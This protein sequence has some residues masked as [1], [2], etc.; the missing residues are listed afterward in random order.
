MKR[1]LPLLFFITS[2]ASFA[3]QGAPSCA[4]LAA[5]SSQYQ[6]C[7]TTITFASSTN[8]SSGE[9]Y[10]PSCFDTNL[11][12]PSWF[13]IKI[14]T[15]GSINFQIQQVNAAGN[16]ADVDFTLWGP[17]T[18]LTNVCSSLT[19]AREVDCSYSP[20]GLENVTLPNGVAGELYVLVIDNFSQTAGNITITQTGGDG[21]SDCSFLSDVDILDDTGNEIL[22]LDYCQP[23]TKNLVA[24]VDTSDF[25]GNPADLRFNY[26]WYKDTVLVYTLTDD[27]SPTNTYVAADSGIYRVEMTSYDVTDP[28]LDPS[29]LTV[30]ADEITLNFYEAPIV[31]VTTS[32]NCLQAAPQLQATVSNLGAAPVSYQWFRGTTSILGA[33]TATYTPTQAGTYFVQASNPGCT[34]VNSNSIVIY[35]IPTVNITGT[36]AICED[37][38]YTLTSAVANTGSATITYQWNKG[39]NPIPGANGATFVVS[40]ANQSPGASE[41]YTL[42]L[43]LDGSCSSVS[44]AVTITLNQKPALAS[45]PVVLKQCDYIAPNTDGVAIFDLTQA[46]TALT[47]NTAGITLSYFLDA[48]LTQQIANP[49]LFTNTTPFNQTLYVTGQFP[50]QVPVCTSNVA[51]LQLDVDPTSVAS[52]PNLAPVCPE[53]NQGFGFFDF[54]TQRALIKTTYFPATNVNIAFYANA[55]DAAVENGALDNT[56][57]IPTGNNTIYTRI[58]TNNDCAGIGTFSADV[59]IAPALTNVVDWELCESEPVIF[60]AKDSEALTG[61]AATVST[62]YFASFENARQNIAAFDKNADANFPI[63]TTTVYARLSDSA[64]GCFSIIDFDVKVYDEPNITAPTPMSNCSGSVGTFNLDSRIAQITGGNANYGVQFFASQAD[65]DSGIAITNTNAYQSGNRTVLI[66]VTDPTQHGCTSQTTL[67]LSVSERPGAATN[68]DILQLCDD[69]GFHAFDL[70]ERERQMAGPTPLAE[71]E[72][73]YYE[74][75]DSAEANSPDWIADPTQYVNRDPQYQKIYVRIN[76]KTSFDSETG[77]PCYRVLE[78]ELFVRH[79]PPDNLLKTPYHICVDKDGN[80]VSPALIE[81]GLSEGFQFTWYE[82]PDAVPGSERPTNQSFFVAT[83]PGT[84]SVRIVDFR[85]TS[86]CDI[87]INFTVRNTEVP[88]SISGNPADLIAF[89]TDNT[90]TAVVDPPSSDYEY[91][92]D[93]NGWQDSNVFVDVKEGLYRLTVRSKYGCGEV[94]TDVVVA[95]FPRFFTPNGD[96]FHDTWNI[97]GQEALDVSV[98]YVFDRNGKLLRSIFR[99]DTGWDGTY[100]GRPMPADDYWFVVLYTKGGITKEFRSHF[101]LKR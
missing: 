57:P 67:T 12:G 65:F 13:F 74:S 54:E 70:T 33:T 52:Y 27:T 9:S 53:L 50:G 36:T 69:S 64:T 28:P 71:L 79:S 96:G 25:T 34:A 30:S 87:V 58:E 15:S 73:F 18:S 66:L 49:S 2:L 72:F 84:Y 76:S 40:S 5:N 75:P 78:L 68:P 17:F 11:A 10:M 45:S 7:A 93:N 61:Q 19:P 23:T 55:T 43:T 80:V 42:T 31:T 85:Y 98:V 94:A 95:D 88:F 1:L 44:N 63:G 101:A 35:P 83:E 41:S 37:D 62:Q 22:Q 100:N 32:S 48:G 56:S 3:Q 89:E 90:L 97:D 21:S 20:S 16:L 86:L 46:A 24:T 99:D 91:Q 39:G 77:L 60:S 81:T 59:Y 4:E 14:A 8:N 51:V 29:T 38:T 82:G 26:K 92:L 6:A 47:N